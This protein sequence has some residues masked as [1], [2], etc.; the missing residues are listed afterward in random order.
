MYS[1]F[2]LGT[3]HLTSL[4]SIQTAISLKP[5][6]TSDFHGASP[7]GSDQKASGRNLKGPLPV[8]ATKHVTRQLAQ[9]DQRSN[10]F[11][12]KIIECYL[13]FFFK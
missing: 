12:T 8:T 3:S 1:T 4:A 6:F 10:F 9:S 11:S 13:L 5:P 2:Y 7:T